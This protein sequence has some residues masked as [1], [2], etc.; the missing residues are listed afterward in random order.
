MKKKFMCLLVVLALVGLMAIPTFAAE[1]QLESVLI[2]VNGTIVEVDLVDY[3]LAVA[4]GSS[5][6]LFKYL[7]GNGDSPLI[8]GVKGGGKYLDLIEYATNYATSGKN[9]STAINNCPALPSEQVNSFKKFTGFDA[10]GQPV[11][12]AVNGGGEDFVVEDIY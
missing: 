11:L 2:N 1:S 6:D 8:S 10:Q 7:K 5:S 12:V 9:I 3:A 4:S